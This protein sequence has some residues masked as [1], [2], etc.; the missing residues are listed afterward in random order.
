MPSGITHI[1]LMKSLQNIL[2][3]DS[4]LKM[5]IAAGRDFLQVGALGPDLPY[6]SVADSD[7]IFSSQSELAD[8]FHYEKTNEIPLRAFAHIRSIRDELSSVSLRNHFSFFLGYLAHVVADGIIHPFVRDKVGDYKANQAEHRKLEMNLDVML[9]HY[10][11]Q[12]SGHPIEFNSSNVHEELMNFD[13][14]NNSD[15]MHVISLFSQLI[16]GVY[17]N[18]Y[19]AE[20]ILDWIKGLHRM[21]GLAEGKHWFIYENLPIIS[22]YLFKDYDKIKGD[23]DQILLLG[24]PKDRTENFLKKPQI[25]FIDDVLP[26]F[27]NTFIPLAQKAYDYVYNDGL[28]LSETDIAAIDLDTGRLLASNNNLDLIPSF[29]G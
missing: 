22:G 12:A 2:P 28:A 10:L 27:Y 20:K 24:S 23:S 3:A 13:E 7:F 29:W 16:Y 26:R 14:R 4:D 25:H 5:E 6:A 8:K 21:F 19:E 9:F 1:L 11:T 18:T 17:G 15:V